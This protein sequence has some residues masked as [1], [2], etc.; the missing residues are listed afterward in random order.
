MKRIMFIGVLSLLVTG[1]PVTAADSLAG[2]WALIRPG[3]EQSIL[4]LIRIEAKGGAYS[5]SVLDADKN[6]AGTQLSDF[7]STADRIQFVLHARGSRFPIEAVAAG[8]DTMLGSVSAGRDISAVRLKR[9]SISKLEDS[10][11]VAKDAVSRHPDDP[12]TFELARSL[13]TQAGAKGASAAEVRSWADK[14]FRSSER[15]GPRMRQEIG[16]QIA[17]ALAGQ[18]D[19]AD[20]AVEYARRTERSM[21]PTE[22]ASAQVRVLDALASALRATGKEADAKAL[23]GRIE[24]L[25]QQADAEYLRAFPPLKVEPFSGS[26]KDNR[27]VLVELFTGAQ[28]PPCVAADIAFDAVAR[29]YKPQDVILLQYHLHIPGPDPLT[30]SDSEARQAYYADAIEGT[31]TMLFNGKPE[32]GGGGPANAAREKLTEYQQVINALLD[33]SQADVKLEATAIRK[34][35][36]ISITAKVSNVAEPSDKLRLRFALVEEQVRYVGGNNI[37]FH[38]HLVRAMPGGAAGFPVTNK[39]ISQT[40]SVNVPALRKQLE[41]YL[42][43][44]ARRMPFSGPQRPPSLKNLMAVAYV[45]N[46]TSR[47]ILQAVQVKIQGEAA[48]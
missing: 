44:A 19:F 48:D 37:R 9:T 47:E 26:K 6:F 40:V 27:T 25:E 33:R 45:Q 12:A 8:P 10:Y 4:W 20:I 29:A 7:A 39:E 36:D 38:H 17:E 42:Q 14:L 11:E 35:D 24:K 23:D 31:P 32:A 22:P 30:N 15:Y 28:C 16:V 46:D 1:A 5:A 41:Q 2:N 18:K 13:F 3:S 21:E 43:D 34:G